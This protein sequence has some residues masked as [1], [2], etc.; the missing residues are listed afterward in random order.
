MPQ[1][2][3]DLDISWITERTRYLSDGLTVQ[4]L[5]YP[6]IKVFSSSIE[7]ET[8]YEE[9][10]YYDMFYDENYSILVYDEV[11]NSVWKKNTNMMA[12]SWKSIGYFI[13]NK[14]KN[15]YGFLCSY[16]T[17]EFLDLETMV[18]IKESALYYGSNSLKS[19]SEKTMNNSVELVNEDFDS[20][21]L[22]KLSN[23]EKYENVFFVNLNL[24]IENPILNA[25]LR[26]KFVWD[27]NLKIYYFGAKYN[28]TYKYIQLG[29]STKNLL[30]MVEGRY[31]LLNNLKKTKKSNLVLYNNNLK[32]L[33][34]PTFHRSLF[35]YL[36]TL[37]NSFEIMYLPKTAASVGSLD[38]SFNRSIVSQKSP[39]S[40]RK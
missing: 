39:S 28:L 24:R 19:L 32:L 30:K 38:I 6:C 2:N 31:S 10:V 7:K 5:D 21:Y 3:T 27:N 20:N 16:Y 33:Y 14:M 15:Q 13:L 34:K 29:V 37:N 25:K 23:F 18:Y 22:L 17:G 11:I 8:I 9:S 1:Y 35:N 26:Q 36:K 4:Q 12:I 40:N